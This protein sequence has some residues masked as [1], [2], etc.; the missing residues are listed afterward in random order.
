MTSI[1]N[2]FFAFSCHV[3]WASPSVP[4]SVRAA[5]PLL[6]RNHLLCSSLRFLDGLTLLDLLWWFLNIQNRNLEHRTTHTRAHLLRNAIL[7][8]K[9]VEVLVRLCIDSQVRITTIYPTNH[10]QERWLSE[11]LF[12][13][14]FW[15]F[16]EATL[17]SHETSCF[18]HYLKA[19]ESPKPKESM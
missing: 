16:S 14:G 10:M 4:E 3:G 11:R 9:D 15:A 6:T 5:E 17:H 13:T 12:E 7:Q 2:S 1:N 8:G 19:G 18:W